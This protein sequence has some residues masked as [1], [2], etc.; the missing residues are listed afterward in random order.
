MSMPVLPDSITGAIPESVTGAI[1]EEYAEYFPTALTSFAAVLTLFSLVALFMCIAMYW[2]IFKKAGYCGIL[3]LIP[4]VN[5]FL[6]VK[7]IF[8]RAWMLFLF[9]IPGVNVI[10]A[11]IAPFRFARVFGR[12]FFFGIGTLFF[13]AIFMAVVAFGNLDY[14]K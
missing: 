1:P 6:F 4:I 3:S 5:A 9:L 14:E 11:L 8:G 10:L 7:I 2:R 12:G 13:P